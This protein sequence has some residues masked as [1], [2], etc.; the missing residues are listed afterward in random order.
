MFT[1]STGTMM[2]ILSVAPIENNGLTI[3]QA[4]TAACSNRA[5]VFQADLSER[6]ARASLL[7]STLWFSPSISAS[8]ALNGM[9]TE[10]PGV[11][12]YSSSIS[13]NANM[14]LFSMKSVG[15][16]RISSVSLDIAE[17]SGRASRAAV[18]YEAAS[19][20][21]SMLQTCFLWQSSAPE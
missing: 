17:E 19:A 9:E 5:E 13:L 12:N 6:S 11:E 7:G 15:N 10:V 16:R 20:W 14:N 1:V 2:L 4:V 18:M 3:D 8:A 21:Y